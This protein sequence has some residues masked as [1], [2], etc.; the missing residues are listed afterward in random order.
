[1]SQDFRAYWADIKRTHRLIRE[2]NICYLSTQN[3][4]YGQIMI[5]VCPDNRGFAVEAYKLGGKYR[6]RT[7][8]WHFPYSKWGEV[9]EL[10]QVVFGQQNIRADKRCIP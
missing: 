10:C 6:P 5:V 3:L 8:C 2:M 7:K 4:R 1:M 9:W